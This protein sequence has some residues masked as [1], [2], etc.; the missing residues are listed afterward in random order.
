MLVH[1]PCSACMTGLPHKCYSFARIEDP[2]RGRTSSIERH[3][4]TAPYSPMADI[5]V[6]SLSN[7]PT[8]RLLPG[9]PWAPLS[10]RD[11]NGNQHYTRCALPST[12]D[13][14][15]PAPRQSIGNIHVAAP[16]QPTYRTATRI[17]SAPPT[18]QANTWPPAVLTPTYHF[19]SDCRQDNRASLPYS[20][21]ANDRRRQA[22]PKLR[23]QLFVREKCS[24]FEPGN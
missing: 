24:G 23:T 18:Q 14:S 12:T 3:S 13:K 7:S 4:F 20:L 9:L 22:L 11:S 16:S 6:S 2:L 1:Q 19:E 10:R 5:S 17:A 21:S 8:P 15:F